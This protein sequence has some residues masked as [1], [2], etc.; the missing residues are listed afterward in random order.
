MQVYT[1]KQGGGALG[2]VAF[3][4]RDHLNAATVT[5]LWNTD[6][7]WVPPGQSVSRIIVQGSILT[8]QRNECAKRMEGDWLLFI[9]DDMVWQ[10]GDIGRLVESWHEVQDQ[11]LEP[12]I[13]GGLCHRRQEPYDPTLYAREQPNS[14]RYRFIEKWD[15]D[16]IEVDATGMAFALIPVTVFEQMARA[17]GT[18]WPSFEERKDKVPPPL[19]KWDGM[20]GEDLGFCADAKLAGCRVFVDTRIKIGH[21]AEVTIDERW[22]L[23]SIAERAPEVEEHVRIVNMVAGLPTM[24][25]EEARGRLAG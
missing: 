23:R 9:D 4:S 2:T 12:V 18:V 1:G 13:L 5:S 10:P 19:F 16:I 21:I 17:A 6:F 8:L 25:A 20:L 24:S 15:S 7:S 14:G 11:F 3:C 22:F